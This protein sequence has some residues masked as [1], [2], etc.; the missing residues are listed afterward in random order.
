[1]KTA[2]KTTLSALIVA[3]ALVSGASSAFAGGSYYEG[4]SSTPDTRVY[5]AQ[6]SESRSHSR[7]DPV[8]TGSVWKHSA[9]EQQPVVNG[10]EGD[11]YQGA[12]RR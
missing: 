7:I 4:A 5:P 8:N 2:I 11:Y 3:S 6:S 10:G 9:R 1:M 12:I